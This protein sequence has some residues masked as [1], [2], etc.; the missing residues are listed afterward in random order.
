MK[1]KGLSPRHYNILFHTHTIAG[2]IA[3]FVLFVIFYAGA[4]TLFRSEFYQWENIQARNISTR[5]INPQKIIQTIQ[6][7]Q[8]NTDWNDDLRIITPTTEEPLI[9]VRGHIKTKSRQE[10]HF[11]LLINPDNYSVL[12]PTTT[13]GETLYRLHFFDQIPIVGRYISGFVALIFLF[14][15]ISGVLIH[16][17][18]ITT[19]F[20]GFSIKNGKK[21]LWASAHTVLGLLGLPFQLM[22]AVTGAFYLLLALILLPALVF[23]YNGNVTEIYKIVQ[24]A[25]GITY[26]KN[27]PQANN[28]TPF[29]ELVDS[30]KLHHPEYHI[31]YLGLKN[32]A[33]KDG[34]V[35]INLINQAKENFDV[36]ASIGYRFHRKELLYRL[37]PQQSKKYTH[38]V[39]TGLG[40]LHF[41]TF[42]G[43]AVKIIYFILAMITCFVITSG[44]LLWK[45]ARKSKHYNL[46]QQCFHQRV[47][48]IYMSFTMG[49]V[50]AVP[51]L[52][53]LELIIPSSDKH[54]LWVNNIFFISWFVFCLV[55]I[56]LKN[57]ASI[58]KW[59]L[60]VSAILSIIVPLTNGF[61][62]NDWIWRTSANSQLHTL[63]TDI[64]WI[65]ISIVCA[66]LSRVIQISIASSKKF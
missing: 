38:Q 17:K 10:Q 50:P 11:E 25:T 61:I 26:E 55:G 22:Y 46:K 35:E 48:T 32:F 59:M 65:C 53:I 23:F 5:D 4:F 8:P 20:W 43:V 2:I 18:N 57:E 13:I 58:T 27:C 51:L 44:I 66:I 15:T 28:L 14:A 3:S 36:Y 49:L 7:V 6:K 42:G 39:I 9:E 1:N 56:F 40:Q 62:T 29:I 37:V 30:I 63:I 19:K 64:S 24:P 52:F 45:E 60:S 21:Q 41:A 54:I 47:T 34:T 12:K 31:R 33:K 16:W